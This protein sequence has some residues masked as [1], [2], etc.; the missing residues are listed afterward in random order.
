MDDQN[1]TSVSMSW[2]VI[3]YPSGWNSCFHPHGRYYRFFILFLACTFSFGYFFSFDLPSVLEDPISEL[4]GL[5]SV[6]Y[7]LFYSLFSW[8]TCVFVIPGGVFIDRVNARS[9]GVL[10]ASI[11]VVGQSL[12]ALG[13]NLKAYWLMCFGRFCLGIGGALFVVQM[14]I[15]SRYFKGKEMALAYGVIIMASR[16]GSVINFLSTAR[17]EE[18]TSLAFV[19][20]YSVM[21][22]ILSLAFACFFFFFERNNDNKFE[23]VKKETKKI[24][25][26]DLLTFPLSYWVLTILLT[27]EFICLFS[28]ISNG[29]DFLQ[30]KYDFESQ[31]SSYVVGIIYDMAILGCPITGILLDRFGKRTLW[32]IVG[33]SLTLPAFLLF[34]MSDVSPILGT[35][36][37]GTSYIIVLPAVWPSIPLII[38]PNHVGTATGLTNAIAFFGVGMSNLVIGFLLDEYSDVFSNGIGTELDKTDGYI[39]VNAFLFSV[40][41]VGLIAAILLFIIDQIRGGVLYSHKSLQKDEKQPLMVKQDQFIGS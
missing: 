30:T 24:H 36:V 16:L 29:V 8:A 4:L 1:N 5:T 35:F 25:L 6:Q 21:M 12:F 41:C 28:Y 26:S 19:L 32:M 9:A 37:L 7:N 34:M 39:Y 33:T 14:S 40:G 22:C 27:T 15:T 13:G 2:D 38:Q 31:K 20:W 11:T 23:Q 10:F 17:L 18:N 3:E